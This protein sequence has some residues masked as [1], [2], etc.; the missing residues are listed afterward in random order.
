MCQSRAQLLVIPDETRNV[1][2]WLLAIGLL[3]SACTFGAA[4]LAIRRTYHE[5]LARALKDKYSTLNLQ[6]DKVINDANAEISSSHDQI[7]G[8]HSETC[9]IEGRADPEHA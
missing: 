8:R 7:N 5:H 4:N 3:S 1:R 9:Y 6:M 2:V